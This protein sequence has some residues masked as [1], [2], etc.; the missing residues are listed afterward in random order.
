MLHRTAKGRRAQVA[1][2]AGAAI[3]IDSADGDAG[4]IGFG[5]VGGAVGVA[6]GNAVIVHDEIAVRQAAQRVLDVAVGKA[7]TVDVLAGH[8]G[9]DGQD[10]GVVRRV[11]D[12]VLDIGLVDDGLRLHRVQRGLGRRHFG[13]ESRARHDDGFDVAG[14]IRLSHLL[15]R[16]TAAPEQSRDQDGQ[17]GRTAVELLEFRINM[18]SPS[19]SF[20]TRQNKG[21]GGI[22]LFANPPRAASM[23]CPVLCDGSPMSV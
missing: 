15:R 6:E 9:R 8:G 1:G 2:I 3:H 7:R 14:A 11:G 18:V 13:V 17:S 20:T 23:D 22:A 4:E 21:V 5:M 12:R 10:G 19:Q 16:G